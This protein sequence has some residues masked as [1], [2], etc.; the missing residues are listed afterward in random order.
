MSKYSKSFQ[1]LINLQLEIDSQL[2]L[3]IQKDIQENK[4]PTEFH[5]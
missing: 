2:K 3:F 5:D 4:F 1:L